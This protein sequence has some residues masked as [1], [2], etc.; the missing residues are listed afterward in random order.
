LQQYIQCRYPDLKVKFFNAGWSGD[1]APGALNRLERDVLSLNPTVVTL[2]FGMNDGSYTTLND[3]ILK[4]YRDGMEG[5]IKAL[6]AKNVRVIVFTPGCVDYDRKKDLGTCDYN[7]TL[8]ALGNACKELAEKYKCDFVDVHHPMVTFQTEQKAKQSGYTMIPDS[9]HPDQKGHLVMARHML[10]AFAEP[11]PLLGTVDLNANTAEGLQIV[12]KSENQVVLKGKLK[13]FPFWI[14]PN[15]VAAARDCGMADFAIPKLIVK[16]LQAGSYDVLVDGQPVQRGISEQDLASGA[17]MPVAS[18]YAKMLYDLVNAKENNYFNA[19][20]NIRLQ[21][22]DKEYMTP[23]YQG[24]MS[25]DD[26]YQNAI[27]A[28]A[29]KLPEITITIVPKPEGGNIALK[30]KYECSDPNIYNWGIGGLTDGSWKGGTPDCFA[31]GENATFPK[32]VTIELEKSAPV[33]SVVIGVPEFGS[34][35]TVK[36]S[37]S[38]D[39]KEFTDVGTYDFSLRKE[40]RHTF[41]FSPVNAKYVRLTYV[42]NYKENVGY[43]PNFAFTTEV[44]VYAKAAK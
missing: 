38:E 21:I 15:S 4:T 1:R 43:S 6:Q 34:T 36:V 11:A 25:A 19:W 13:S 44:E 5:I 18:P 8:E 35:K 37:L 33:S 40:E 27:W 29:G 9:V 26:G 32:H 41:S 20:R 10:T 23:I 7:K 3:N 14:D 24:L 12:S 30:R 39:N 17:S 31:T 16:G 28:I 22:Q 2:F 42:E